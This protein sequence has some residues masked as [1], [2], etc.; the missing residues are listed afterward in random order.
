M[1]N[2]KR[3]IEKRI[4]KELQEQE[5]EMNV[6]NREATLAMVEKECA[7]AGKQDRNG[8][9]K[10]FVRQMKYL[11][12][13][14]W[15]LQGV[16]LM[17]ILL[18]LSYAYGEQ[19]VESAKEFAIL[20]C[21]SA[22]LILLTMVPFIQRSV[23]YQMNAVEAATR[24]SSGRIL[25]AKLLTIGLGDGVM[26]LGLIIFN[27]LCTSLSVPQIIVFLLVPFLIL[28]SATLHLLRHVAADKYGTGCICVGLLFFLAVL[29]GG[30]VAPWI[31][32]ETGIIAWVITALAFGV[33]TTYQIRQLIKS[34]VIMELQIG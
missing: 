8:F 16:I 21:G 1:I 18:F 14:I 25:A 23:R 15:C 22:I 24:F 30:E 6:L 9:F 13:P 7:R 27:A 4:R 20:L 17:L 5:L 31:F 29:L 19:M 33:F 11:S 34:S 2:E 12:V 28:S 32:A 26:I 3:K 10:F